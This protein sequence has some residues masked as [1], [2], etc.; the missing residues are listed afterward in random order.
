[1]TAKIITDGREGI[2]EGYGIASMVLGII[3][4]LMFWIPYIAPACGITGLVL[5][6]KQ[7]KHFKTG[8]GSA[9]LVLSII[10]TILSALWSF[11]FTLGILVAI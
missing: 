9:G 6:S 11:F 1:M 7:K 8:M 4:I 2:K 3:S 5:A 10:G